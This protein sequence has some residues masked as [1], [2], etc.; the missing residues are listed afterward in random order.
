MARYTGSLAAYPARAAFAWFALLILAGASLLSLPICQAA[1]RPPVSLLDALF[2]AASAACVTGLTVRSTVHDF[3]F[4]GQLVILALI[5]LGGIGIITVTTFLTL[6]FGGREHLRQ[7]AVIASTL[8]A[9]DLDLRW[10]LRNAL[11]FVLVVEGIGFTVLAGRNLI[12]D[13]GRGGWQAVWDGLFHSVSAFCNAGFALHDDNLVRHQGDVLVNLTIVSLLVVGGIGFPV[14]LDLRRQGNGSWRQRWERLALHTKMMLIGTGGLLTL[15]TVLILLLE[16]NHA[17]A[18]MP[19]GRKLLVAAFQSATPRTA[20]F[21]TIDLGRFSDATLFIIIL[22]MLIGGGPCSTAGGFKV[23]TVM[24]LLANTWSKFTGHHRIRL[25]RRSISA[26][27]VERALATALIFAV[28]AVT[29]V[30]ALLMF[31]SATRNRFLPAVFEV[32]SALG[33]VGLSVDFTTTL[34]GTG[35]T[36]II[37]LM[38]VGR[39][40]PITVFVAL[41]RKAHQDRLEYPNEDV[42]I[43]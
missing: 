10:V 40:G 1:D 8:G 23:S 29:A 28:V 16:W 19:L 34:H 36:I 27:V 15:G 30:T 9:I 31:E 21:N 2:T 24:V 11:Q 35:K 22:L 37:I 5:Q 26:E 33:T 7:K 12:F 25:F 6:R 14:I 41:A 4:L 3:S 20:G 43:G 32:A 13:T 18:E 39:L 38:F 42:L 17:L